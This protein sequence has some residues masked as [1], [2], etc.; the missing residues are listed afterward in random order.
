M[1]GNSILIQGVDGL[2]YDQK[3]LCLVAHL[4]GYLAWEVICNPGLGLSGNYRCQKIEINSYP[5]SPLFISTGFLHR[6]S[7][8]RLN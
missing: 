8:M 4:F 2:V 1:I 6:V 7:S 5:D 3:E